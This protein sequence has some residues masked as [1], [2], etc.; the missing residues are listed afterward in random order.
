MGVKR[1]YREPTI[2]ISGDFNQWDISGYL[3][4]FQEIME[5]DVGPTRS[6][7]S[8]DRI[9]SSAGREMRACGKVTP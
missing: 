7:A 3:E 2:F 4:D 6:N 1:R 8:I 5:A 9:F